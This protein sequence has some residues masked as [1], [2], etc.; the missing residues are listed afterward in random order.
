MKSRRAEINFWNVGQGL[1]HTAKILNSLLMYDC[2]SKTTSQIEL[3]IRKIAARYSSTDFELLVLSHLHTDHINGLDDLLRS[4]LRPKRVAIPYVPAIERLMLAVSTDEVPAWYENFLQDPIAYFRENRVNEVIVLN[5][6]EPDN[7][8]SEFPTSP[9]PEGDQPG[10]FESW[11]EK[12]S[13]KAHIDPN[14]IFVDGKQK[15]STV[16]HLDHK[17]I[18]N[19][20]GRWFFKFFNKHAPKSDILR[21]QNILQSEGITTTETMLDTLRDRKKLQKLRQAYGHISKDLNDTSLCLFHGPITEH[22]SHIRVLYRRRYPKYYGVRQSGFMLTGDFNIYQN[23]DFEEFS[24]HYHNQLGRIGYYLIPHHGSG[25]GWQEGLVAK[26]R[27]DCHWFYSA[28]INRYYGHPDRFVLDRLLY[29]GIDF[30]E[31]N[32]R[33]RACVDVHF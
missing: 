29:H 4:S 27:R 22:F 1:C 10:K 20:P 11:K 23:A 17:S 24:A 18:F 33:N 7:P 6:N 14:D 15:G 13:G 8:E 32:E 2:G 30:F 9:N 21:F 3:V 31:L 28:S 26:L 19:I 12:P 16:H 5:G 25:T